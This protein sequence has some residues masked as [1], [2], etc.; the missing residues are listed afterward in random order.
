[1]TDAARTRIEFRQF[2]CADGHEFR[3]ACKSVL[4]VGTDQYEEFYKAVH[5]NGV[6]VNVVPVAFH[7]LPVPKC[8]YEGCQLIGDLLTDPTASRSAAQVPESER[9][10]AWL[11]PDGERVAV[12]G[13][14]G[15]KMPERYRRA[16]Y[17]VVEAANLPQLQR[18]EQVRAR[19]TGNST[20]HEMS[21]FD[22]ATRA[23]RE[24][25]EYSDDMTS[26]T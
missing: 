19:Q 22:A 24:R 18:L 12:P 21:S 10:Y 23:A 9:F 1:M 26:D 20:Y 5:T 8:P 25:A 4:I 2:K 13:Y 11:S 3:A 17:M 7:W 14:R 6:L 15:A 16:G